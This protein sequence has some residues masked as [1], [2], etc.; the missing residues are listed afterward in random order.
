MAA[1][2]SVLVLDTGP[3]SNA[4]V[5]FA[6]PGK[7]PTVSQLCRQWLRDCERAGALLVVPAITYYESLRELERRG[8]A[9]Q[10]RRLKQFVFGRPDRLLPL[11]T[12]HLES[13]AALWGQARRAGI[14]TASPEAL[15]AD[16][17]LA[18]QALSLGLAAPDYLVATTNVGHL[19]RFVPADEW[20]NIT[21]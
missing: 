6:R 4:A 20:T 14:P 21:P 5:A 13:A 15:D 1:L 19:S 12:A 2:R 17:I 16:V 11:T 7:T 18:A 10:I 9:G 3:L 8:A